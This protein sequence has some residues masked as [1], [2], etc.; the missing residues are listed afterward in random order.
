MPKAGE[1]IV[2]MWSKRQRKGRKKKGVTDLQ[3]N[4]LALVCFDPTKCVTN[5]LAEAKLHSIYLT[6]NVLDSFLFHGSNFFLPLFLFQ[7]YADMN[8]E[9]FFALWNTADR[10]ATGQKQ[11]IVFLGEQ[12]NSHFLPSDSNFFPPNCLNKS[13]QNPPLDCP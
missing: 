6:S 4:K 3:A 5:F 8:A 11:L 10:L 9:N 1:V 7:K 12:P 2:G 13:T